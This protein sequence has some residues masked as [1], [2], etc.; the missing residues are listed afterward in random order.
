[1]TGNHEY[2]ICEH[3]KRAEEDRDVEVDK[4]R[5]ILTRGCQKHLQ[6]SLEEFFE[7]GGNQC[8]LCL[9]QT[10]IDLQT[11]N[12]KLIQRVHQLTES[13]A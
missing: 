8:P 3:L 9:Q 10:V 6:L 1:M 4:V 2:S 13:A 5:C 11:E 12:K 7:A